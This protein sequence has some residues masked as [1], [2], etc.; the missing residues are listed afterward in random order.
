MTSNHVPRKK[1]KRCGRAIKATTQGEYGPVCAA[2]VA[3]EIVRQ[4]NGS[5]TL[6]AVKV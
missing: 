6:V 4:M 3:S 1:C 5:G 2:K